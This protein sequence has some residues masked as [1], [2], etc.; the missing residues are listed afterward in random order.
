LPKTNKQTQ[1]E[2]KTALSEGEALKGKIQVLLV[3]ILVVIVSGS[4][5]GN[6]QKE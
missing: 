5:P 2:L 1:S 4:L 3:M 6:L